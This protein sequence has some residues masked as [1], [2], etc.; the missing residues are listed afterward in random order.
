MLAAGRLRAICA[1][2]APRQRPRPPC[3]ATSAAS[4]ASVAPEDPVATRGGL[5]GYAEALRRGATTATAAAQAYLAR[6]AALDGKLQCYEHVAADSA[7]AEAAALDQEAARGD[8]PGAGLFGV[9]VGVKDIFAIEGTPVRCGSALEERGVLDVTSLVGPEGGFVRQLRACGAVLL[10]KTKTVEFA[11]GGLGINRVRGTPWNPADLETH[12]I[13]GGSSSGS[14]AAVGAGLCGLAVGS[15]TGG[16]VRIPAALCGIFGLK[17]TAGLWPTDG[18]L[19]YSATFDSIG[20]LTRSAA[21][22]STAF[23]ALQGTPPV[24]AGPGTLASAVFGVPS[25]YFFDDLEKGVAE[26][27]SGAMRRLEAA[28]AT[29]VPIDL[30]AEL[31][32]VLGLRLAIVPVEFTQHFGDDDESRRENWERALPLMG[33]NVHRN[34]LGLEVSGGDYLRAVRRVG[35]LRLEVEAKLAAAGITA[36]LTPTV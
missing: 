11:S 31:S 20:L 9:P 16:S 17:T 19:P 27:V 22:A 8:G 2:T 30:E 18:V 5:E 32:E 23:A 14:A 13:P 35:S 12:R 33:S 34:A 28:G 26:A 10:G 15:D 7:L 6:I 25:S 24:Q 3:R 21:D 36:L 29:L 1:H 4:T